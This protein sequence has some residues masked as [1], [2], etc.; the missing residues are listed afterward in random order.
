MGQPI[1]SIDKCARIE[2]AI[3]ALARHI[4]DASNP[5][6]ARNSATHMAAPAVMGARPV[7]NAAPPADMKT[8]L[9]EIAAILEDLGEALADLQAQTGGADNKLNQGGKLTNGSLHGFRVPKADGSTQNVK[10]T[11]A[12]GFLLPK[13]D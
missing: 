8:R 2:A 11:R 4:L 6:P 10:V 3:D 5:S 7:T 9:A 12:G 13:G 1:M